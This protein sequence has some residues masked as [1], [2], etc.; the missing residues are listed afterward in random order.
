MVAPMRRIALTAFLLLALACGGAAPAGWTTPRSVELVGE[1]DRPLAARTIVDESGVRVLSIR[2]APG[3]RLPEHVIP[4]PVCITA[5]AGEGTVLVD[6]EPHRLDGEHVVLVPTGQPHVVEPAP[7]QAL[8]LVVH[9]LRGAR[10]PDA[11]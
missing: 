8:L 6:G 5:V 11:P 10:G 3:G 7:D 4:H 9:Q 2:I 1:S